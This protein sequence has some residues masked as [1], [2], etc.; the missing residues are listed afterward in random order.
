[1]LLAMEDPELQ[2]RREKSRCG[3][4]SH[5]C[6]AAALVLFSAVCCISFLIIQWDIDNLKSIVETQEKRID[7]LSKAPGH[8]LEETTTIE[9]IKVQEN[10]K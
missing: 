7:E 4:M 8:H 5:C 10:V 2:V 1:M 6:F 3:K 9:V